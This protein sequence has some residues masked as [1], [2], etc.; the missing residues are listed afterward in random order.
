M[1]HPESYSI[2]GIQMLANNRAI[3]MFKITGTTFIE[4]FPEYHVEQNGLQGMGSILPK[5]PKGVRVSP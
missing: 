1:N 5:S 4:P 3:I 2:S